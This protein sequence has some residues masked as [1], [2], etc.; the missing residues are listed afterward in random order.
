ML[1][2]HKTCYKSCRLSKMDFICFS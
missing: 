1:C 2:I